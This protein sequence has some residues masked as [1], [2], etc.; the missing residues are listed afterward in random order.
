MHNHA[1]PHHAIRDHLVRVLE[2]KEAHAMRL[3]A[4]WHI[5]DHRSDQVQ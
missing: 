4:R 3:V 5:D 1:M 2:W